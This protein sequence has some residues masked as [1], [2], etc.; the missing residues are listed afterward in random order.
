MSR[1]PIDLPAKSAAASKSN[2]NLCQITSLFR[3]RAV[4]YI[5][6]DNLI[7]FQTIINPGLEYINVIG[8]LGI[9]QK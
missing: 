1:Q 3:P 6:L 2:F 9:K 7:M 5:Q 4:D 8:V